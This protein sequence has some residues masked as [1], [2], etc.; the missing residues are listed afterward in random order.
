M[1][2]CVKCY[3]V[4][5]ICREVNL[6]VRDYAAKLKSTNYCWSNL[7]GG[8]FHIRHFSHMVM[9]MVRLTLT[10]WVFSQMMSS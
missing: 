8:I 5:N 7:V 9:H 6:V 10:G 2:K 1:L 4:R 3:T